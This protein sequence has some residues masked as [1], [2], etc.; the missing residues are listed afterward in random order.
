MLNQKLVSIGVPCFNEELNVVP[1]YHAL[2]KVTDKMKEY[3]FE[4]IYVDNGSTDGTRNQMRTIAAKDKRITCVFLTRN[5]GPE[6]SGQAALDHVSGDAFITMAGDLQ[7]P[8][9]LIAQ[10]IKKWEEGYKVVFGIYTN[11]QDH[12]LL[13][14]IRKLFYF[15]YQKIS[16]IHVP[17]NA[18][19]YSLIDDQVIKALKLFPEKYRFVRGLKVWV[20]F[21]TAYVNYKK[22]KRKHG[23]SG[24]NL[25]DYIKH[26][27]RGVFG[28][29]YLPLDLIIYLGFILVVLSF[30]FIIV[31]LLLFF[32]YGNPI[33]GAV[34]LLVSI[35]FFGGVQL[36]AISV[37]GK[38]IQVIVEETKARPLY[39]VD[40]VVS[41]RIAPATFAAFSKERPP[42]LR[43]LLESK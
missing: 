37:V 13:T 16:S 1:L 2:K 30:L 39:I 7:D 31:Y 19:G 6:A 26:G 3:N 24:Y 17:V 25:F 15:V 41:S 42:K 22:D 11:S 36:L 32:L 33:K 34:T 43:R 40:E 5:F 18:T 12:F 21:K 14:V 9:D 10:F 20:G 8:P 29:S 27:E 28:F 35:I 4:F 38:Y 23:R